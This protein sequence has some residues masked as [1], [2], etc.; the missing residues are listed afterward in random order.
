MIKLYLLLIKPPTFIT[1]TT[2]SYYYVKETIKS[3]SFL[4]K[5]N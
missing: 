5:T 1:T 3:L 2:K 4:I